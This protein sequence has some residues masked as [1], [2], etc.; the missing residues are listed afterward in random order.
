MGTR[1]LNKYI[2]AMLKSYKINY[3]NYSKTIIGDISFQKY[4]KTRQI[5]PI[6]EIVDISINISDNHLNYRQENPSYV[7][8]FSCGVTYHRDM[9]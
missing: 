7:Y 5:Q 3:R 2:K 9:T 1:N 6:E 8:I 4:L